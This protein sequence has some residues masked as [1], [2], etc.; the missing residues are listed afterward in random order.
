MG[1]EEL[2]KG[3]WYALEQAGVLLDISV[4]LFDA[5]ERSTAVGLAMLGREE[6]GRH[7]I[8]RDFAKEA[9]TESVSVREVRT[10]CADHIEKQANAVNS[11]VFKPPRDSALGKAIRIG[12]HEPPSSP[13]AIAA[14]R[15]IDSAVKAQRRRLPHERHERRMQAFYV[16]VTDSG[17]WARP[18]TFPREEAREIVEHAV[19]DY[20]GVFHNLGIESYAPDMTSV[21]KSMEPA[22][23]LRP[24]RWPKWP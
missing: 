5:G 16:D 18:L 23:Q 12:L 13:N 14:R 8:L 7:H 24:P 11:H 2:L 9:T 15:V 20:S 19:N 17:E 3:A 4:G 1:E 21:G 10:K 6:L 22:P